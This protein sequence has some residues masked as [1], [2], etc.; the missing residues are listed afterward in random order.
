MYN[1]TLSHG[2]ERHARH[3]LRFLLFPNTSHVP[4]DN[5]LGQLG[6]DTHTAPGL[7]PISAQSPPTSITIRAPNMRLGVSSRRAISCMNCQSAEPFPLCLSFPVGFGPKTCVLDSES[8][9][10]GLVGLF[11]AVLIECC[12]RGIVLC[13]PSLLMRVFHPISG[14]DG[15][16]HH[17][18]SS[19]Y[20][21]VRSSQPSRDGPAY[22]P[23]FPPVPIGQTHL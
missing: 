6:P 2:L 7:S 9:G 13:D 22:Y 16:H 1:N 19:R 5:S 20:M 8:R 11:W 17:E 14:C 21:N 10:P 15:R 4:P 3:R 12:N 18:A 23:V